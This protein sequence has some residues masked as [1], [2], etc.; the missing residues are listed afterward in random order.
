MQTMIIIKK[1]VT[2]KEQHVDVRTSPLVL[3]HDSSLSCNTNQRL[4]YMLLVVLIMRLLLF[5]YKYPEIKKE[6]NK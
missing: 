4:R 2:M 1:N 5:L 3:Y 6:I